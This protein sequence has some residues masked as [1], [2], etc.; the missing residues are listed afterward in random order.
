MTISSWVVTS[1][2]R[3]N[4]VD[5][6][7]GHL[8]QTLLGEELEARDVQQAWKQS[9]AWAVFPLLWRLFRLSNFYIKPFD[10]KNITILLQDYVWCFG[11]CQAEPHHQKNG[12]GG[13]DKHSEHLDMLFLFFYSLSPLR[14]PVIQ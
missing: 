8:R 13:R 2:A 6:L 9:K 10:S 11:G 1:Q 7:P 5:C 4:H 3:R 12:A 14:T